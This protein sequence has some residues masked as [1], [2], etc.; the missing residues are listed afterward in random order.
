MKKTRKLTS[1]VLL[2]AM[3]FLLAAP[4]MATGTDTNAGTGSITIDNA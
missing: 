2:I 1:I 3:L 4:A